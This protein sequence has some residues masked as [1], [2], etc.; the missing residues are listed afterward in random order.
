MDQSN[1]AFR[2][3]T[4]ST[5]IP[6]E[7]GVRASGSDPA[8]LE[9][10]YAKLEETVRSRR[11]GED[12]TGLRLAF[13][14]AQASH[15]GQSRKSGEPYLVH[16]LHVAQTLAERGMDMVTLQTAL[17]HDVLEDTPITVEDLKKKFGEDVARCVNGVTKL[18]KIG[19]ASRE[20]RQA[21]SLR[22]MLLAMVDDI[23]V[24]IVKL[25][26]RLHN[27]QTLDSLPRD[28]QER[29]AAETIELYAPIAHR[30]G[31]GV[32][33]GELEDL[34]FKY[35]DPE[36]FKEVTEAIEVRRQ[37]NEQSLEDIR[38]TVERKLSHEMIPARI[39]GRVK[40]P[41]SVYQKLR[42]QKIDIDQVYDLLGIRII[43]DS[44]KNCYAALGVIHNEWHPIPG[45][46]KDFIAIP[47]PNLYQSL[48]TS[49]MGPKGVAFEVQIRTEEMHRIAEE[50]I[51]A[52]W[53][54]KEGKKGAIDDDQRVAWLRQL[55]EWQ[56]EMR[57]PGDFMSSL[58]VDLYPEEVYCFTPRGKVVVLPREATPVDFA[59]A[60]HTDVGHTC[61]GAKVNGRMVPL[62]HQ[63][64]NGDI[65]EIL[66]STNSQ[67]SRDWLS[68]VRTPRAR[69]KIRHVINSSEREKAIDLG[70][71]LIEREARR[72]GVG[73][74]RV[75][76]AQME[77]V[78]GEYGY[79]K[80]EDLQA[81][82]GWGKFSARQVLAKLAPET[83]PQ[84]STP[85]PSTSQAPDQTQQ[86]QDPG[87]D[88]VIQVKGINDLLTYR[89]KC[90]N[91]IRGE[92]IVGYITRGKGV[93]V[94]SRTCSNVQ[95]LMYEAERRIEVEWARGGGDSFHV[96]LVIHTDDRTGIL[97]QL[98][99][100]L[101]DEEISI[102]S[103]EARADDRR[104]DSATVELTIE[105]RDKKQLERVINT[106]RRVAGVRDIERKH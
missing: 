1:D 24:I 104:F 25:A 10:L 68:F 86:W 30:L 76:R 74:S 90:C 28:K 20:A 16:P 99:Q 96:R 80:I 32:I 58:K 91:P 59:Y 37:A 4:A 70:Q 41:W 14:V 47:R 85:V 75:T 34:G 61:T 67:P 31:M 106:M 78:A 97:A 77:S 23:R 29:I 73:L 11:P 53:K 9:A 21:E 27:M 105:V 36:A 69:N 71:K 88:Y 18:S 52:H 7:L 54:Y 83:A 65:V 87:K 60:I 103:V 84:E 17:L 48:H 43:T 38:K 51:A 6:E 93:A 5:A 13:E 64:R 98:T 62:K 39:Y 3:V 56:R 89:A 81:A 57:D 40:R 92:P 35:L 15:A 45:R 101:Y 2:P 19:L 82:L 44:V 72:M 63:L 33:R 95:N 50:G 42:K 102:R 12:L 26:D 46:I 55:V 94:H 66:T 49:V 79:S 8:G 100:I 22:K